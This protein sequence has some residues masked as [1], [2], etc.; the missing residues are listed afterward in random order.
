MNIKHYLFFTL[1]RI[2]FKMLIKIVLNSIFNNKEVKIRDLPK[3]GWV[4]G[5][6]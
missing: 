5:K 3:D 1:R 2:L 6:K 4:I